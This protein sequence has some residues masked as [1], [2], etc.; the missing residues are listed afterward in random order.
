MCACL[1]VYNT[2]GANNGLIFTNKKKLI[3]INLPK[4]QKNEILILLDAWKIVISY[5]LGCARVCA[6]LVV[7]N[8]I[9][10][11]KGLI[12]TNKKINQ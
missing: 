10:A 12:F 8:S 5:K 1:A 11:N 2:A 9:S 3:I 7:Y 4:A 6:C